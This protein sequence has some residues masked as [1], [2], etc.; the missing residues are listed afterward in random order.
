MLAGLAFQLQAERTASLTTA[1]L[2]SF[3][4]IALSFVLT[5]ITGVLLRAG[6]VGP[7]IAWAQI[8]FDVLIASSVTTLTGG[9]R[10]P[11]T[12][13]FL[14]AIVGAGVL[15]GARGAVVGVVGAAVGYIGVAVFLPSPTSDSERFLLET[16]TQLL[17][18]VLIAVLAGYV[19]EQLTRT[20]GRLESSERVLKTL[21][22]LQNEIVA[23]MPSGLVTCDAAGLITFINPAAEQIL[24]VKA[25]E[26]V[27]RRAVEEVLPLPR[28]AAA[29]RTELQVN[30]ARGE[31]TLGLSVTPLGEGQGVLIVF[32]DLTE[33]RRVERELDQIDH[34]ATLGRL[35]AQLAHE[36]R[37]PLAAMRGSAQILAADHGEGPGRERLAGVIVR[38][39]DRLAALVEGY[40]RLAR[41]PPPVL[42]PTRLDTVAR[43]TLEL[44]RSD[45][46]FSSV[47]VDEELEP[48]EAVCDASQMKQVLLNLLR[49]A[50]NAVGARRGGIKLRVRRAGEAPSIQVWD[51]AGSIAAEDLNRIFEPFFTKSRGGS[52][53]G[54]STVQTIVQ[55]HGGKI[56]VDS[57]PATGTTFEVTLKPVEEAHGARTGS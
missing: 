16:A 5:L 2:A 43:E 45:A 46:D 35:S 11:F 28:L 55:A 44:L 53:L 33:L 39:A 24:G 50:A 48:L 8:V 7:Q 20:G 47:R 23:A 6:R 9:S 18:Q 14:V 22:D 4:T 19:G 27:A 10:S 54:L 34:L 42:V 1:D 17:A 29:R 21:T 26:L 57:S 52:G 3:G 32:Q 25:A 31:R 30:S 13:L 40:L 15:L 51:S 36:I 37:N 49:N 56:T 41:P 38:E 12:F